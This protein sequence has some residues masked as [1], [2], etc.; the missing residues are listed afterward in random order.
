MNESPCYRGMA[1]RMVSGYLS[2]RALRGMQQIAGI[3]KA[4]M[5]ASLTI[6]CVAPLYSTRVSP[7]FSATL[8]SM[9]R[10]DWQRR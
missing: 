1:R 10:L 7:S 9:I 6:G 3:T 2:R 8:V 5:K 4:E